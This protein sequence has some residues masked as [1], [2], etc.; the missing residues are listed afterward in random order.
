MERQAKDG[1]IYRQVGQDEW[2]PVTRRA[3]DG[4]TYVKVGQDE[5]TPL[6]QQQPGFIDRA[7]STA[8]NALVSASRF[9]DSFAGAPTR[10]AV[11]AAQEGRNPIG[12]FVGQLG[13][14]PD[15]APSGQEIVKRMGVPDKSTPA[16]MTQRMLPSGAVLPAYNTNP[17]ET[18]GLAAEV[19]LD[20]LNLIGTGAISKTARGAGK[21]LSAA[22][23]AAAKAARPF[24][25]SAKA[26]QAQ[27]AKATASAGAEATAQIS[28]GGLEAT[29][30]GQLFEIKRPQTLDELRSWRPSAGQGEMLGKTRLREIEQIAPDLE[31]KPLKYHY[32]MMENPKAMKDL[33]LTFENLPTDDAKRIA[34]YNQE[35]V[36]EAGSKLQ[37]TIE[38]VGGGFT[39]RSLPEAG[40]DFITTVKAKYDAERKM[41][42]PAFQKLSQTS[43]KL[44]AEESA[45]LITSIGENTK[46][47]KLLTQ[48]PETGRFSLSKNTPRS[49]ISDAEH[50][51]L[52]R[53]IDDLN[54]GMTFKEIQDTRDFL[55]KAV[56]PANPSATA[57]INKVRS[58][59][60][61]QLEGLAAN[62]GPDVGETFKAYAVNERNRE[63]I[64]RIIGGRV[65]DFDKLYRANPDRVVDKIFSNP[66]SVE[67]VTNYVGPEKVKEMVASYLNTGLAKSFDSA[68]GFNPTAARSWLKTKKNADFLSRY[69][70]EQAERIRALA[71]Y[72]WYGKRFL[73]EVNPSGTAASLLSAIE[74]KGFVQQIKQGNIVGAVSSATVGKADALVKQRQALRTL[75][76]AL[77][78]LP[79]STVENIME[80][81]RLQIDRATRN[82]DK[83][84]AGNVGLRAAT[85]ETSARTAADKEGRPLKGKEKWARDG[86]D[87]VQQHVIETSS[88]YVIPENVLENNKAKSLLIN[89]SDLKPGTRAMEN[90]V[91]RLQNLEKKEKGK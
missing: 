22:S 58:V 2:E 26:T 14:N 20:P 64:E 10:A 37:R 63:A 59:L 27:S 19:A 55:R 89:A 9:V 57:E 71:D 78:D 39:P 61:R 49:G 13:D 25:Q 8:G 43:S 11:G 82:A 4:T 56:D 3:K 79:P 35:M 50:K 17:S 33:K 15:L 84:R 86:L 41:L 32:D 7:L 85:A 80:A 30:S 65:E 47:G 60:L 36:K 74:P 44:S 83:I 46:L 81:V 53:V 48:S 29:Q 31:V 34:A 23:E 1:T 75:Q 24:R 16:S 70:P 62:R 42:A 51:V 91:K 18:L 54:D 69:A 68:T 28:G 40:D 52:A 76:E 12:A 90:T 87:K 21:G 6:E 88:G 45:S 77:G 5:W 72:G 73:D 38:E 67:I 66:N